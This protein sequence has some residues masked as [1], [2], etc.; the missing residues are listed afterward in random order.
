M[1][2]VL[3]ASRPRGSGAKNRN[4]PIVGI[5]FLLGIANAAD[6]AAAAGLLHDAEIG[7]RAAISL[8]A[9]MI[10]LIGGRIIPSF[11]R[12]WMTKQGIKH[13]LPT[14]AT[15]FDLGALAVTAAALLAWTATPDWVSAGWLL[16][17]AG[18][19]QVL[20]LS[21]W[22]GLR[23]ARDP[24]VLILHVGFSWVPA[25]LLLLAQHLGTSVPDRLRS[26]LTAG[27][28]ATMSLAVIQI[29]SGS[30]RPRLL[31]PQPSALSLGDD[32]RRPSVAARWPFDYATGM[33]V[34][35]VA[36]TGA[37]V[38]F[39]SPRPDPVPASSGRGL[40]A[41]DHLRTGSNAAPVSSRSAFASPV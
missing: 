13:R 28:L 11:T 40:S 4:L 7:V 22:G 41:W 18:C 38:L 24:L 39:S 21:R 1:Y 2:V 32:W 36:W 35:A 15:P 34:A 20:R 30:Y 33:N 23:C 31:P 9:M 3:A 25:G 29:D 19:A 37:F 12:N 17:A 5:V 8:I 16:I 26:A 10:S 14:Q 6:H 27:A